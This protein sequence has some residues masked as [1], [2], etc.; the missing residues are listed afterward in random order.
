MQPSSPTALSGLYLVTVHVTRDGLGEEVGTHRPSLQVV[1]QGS[2]V[3]VGNC[4]NKMEDTGIDLKPH[5]TVKPGSSES[6]GE[7]PGALSYQSKCLLE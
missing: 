3:L 2:R 7:I 5:S 6:E 4:T 1:V